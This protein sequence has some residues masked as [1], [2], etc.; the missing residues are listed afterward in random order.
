MVG[1]KSLQC[2]SEADSA[3]IL[4]PLLDIV[5]MISKQAADAHNRQARMFSGAVIAHPG[6]GYLKV[7]GHLFGC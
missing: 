6:D 5:G 7:I 3:K 4:K 2:F 1:R